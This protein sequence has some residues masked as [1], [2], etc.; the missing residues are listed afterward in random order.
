MKIAVWDT[1]VTKKDGGIMH[2]DIL[3]PSEVRDETVIFNYGKEYLKSKG[4][5]GQP[6]TAKEC[7]FCHVESMR[8]SWEVDINQQG[9]AIIEME[10]CS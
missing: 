5:E 1:Y 8:P 4:Q 2:F 9:Y 3:A 10:N 7:R 6:L